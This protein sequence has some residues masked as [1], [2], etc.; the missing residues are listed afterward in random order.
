MAPS[1]KNGGIVCVFCGPRAGWFYDEHAFNEHAEHCPCQPP[2]INTLVETIGRWNR[3]SYEEVRSEARKLSELM[4][5][6][7]V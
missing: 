7:G 6:K 5:R 2:D 3:Y 1:F 4:Q